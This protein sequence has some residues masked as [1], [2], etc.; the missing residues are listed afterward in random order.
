MNSNKLS[1]SVAVLLRHVSKRQKW[2][3]L[4]LL[5]LQISAALSEV[6]SLGAVLPFLAALSNADHLL[7]DARFALFFKNLG[8]YTEP[9][10]I[11]AMAVTFSASLG[12]ANAL[13]LLTTWCQ[14]RLTAS[15]GSHLAA[16]IFKI[17][18]HQPYSY[19]VGTNSS[20]LISEITHDLNSTVGAIQLFFLL[21][22][23]G[24][25]TFA[26][27]AALAFIDAKIAFAV[28]FIVGGSYA[29]ILQL[30]RRRLAHNSRIVTENNNQIIKTLQE[31]IGGIRDIILDRSQAYFVK[32]FSRADLFVRNAQTETSF[33]RQFPRYV[34]ETIGV[35]ALCATASV[36]AWEGKRLDSILPLLGALTLAATRLLPAMQ[37]VFASASGIQGIDASVKRTVSALERPICDFSSPETLAISV[38]SEIKLVNVWLNYD[39]ASKSQ[40]WVLKGIDLSIP[41]KSTVAFIGATGSGKSSAA[42]ILLGLLAPQRGE[43]IVDGRPITGAGINAWRESIAHVPQSIYLSDNSFAENIAFGID[44][45][46]IDFARVKECADSAHISQFIESLPNSYME[47]VGER[48][49]RL[50]GGQRQRI[51]IARALYKRASVIVFDEATSALDV[52]TEKEVMKAIEE[53][54][55]RMTVILIAHRLSTIKHA[56]NIYQFKDGTAERLFALPIDNSESL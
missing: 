8:I 11:V 44:F 6:V 12:A 22:T 25:T 45:S 24:L 18:L 46:K 49:I 20:Q 34:L 30:S 7:T 13:R 15:I 33:L 35:L 36:L 9:Q 3:M 48:G 53:L 16:T 43:L 52:A 56:Q 54:G 4:G 14:M 38:K 37:Q 40:N 42:D 23:N 26:I 1:N 55:S 39:G 50:S 31:G 51:G 17:T 27:V 19:H 29:A 41:A 2:Q 5:V 32:N 28:L 21:F 47:R 10:L